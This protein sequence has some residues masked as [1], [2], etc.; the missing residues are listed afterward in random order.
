EIDNNADPSVTADG[1]HFIAGLTDEG[2]EVALG[3][4][5]TAGARRLLT[6]LD[7]AALGDI[8]WNTSQV[9]ASGGQ[10]AASH[11]YTSTGV[12]NVMVRV[13]DSNGNVAEETF[14]VTVGAPQ[15]GVGDPELLVVT[16]LDDTVALDGFVSLRE[17]ILAINSNTTVGDAVAGPSTNTIQFAVGLFDSPG[18][19]ELTGGEL[20][21]TDEVSILGPG[22]SLLTIDAGFD[23]R[24]FRVKDFTDSVIDVS[25]SGLTLANGRQ[26]DAG[27]AIFNTENLT[28]DDVRLLDSDHGSLPGVTRG[29][30]IYTVGDLAI[31]NSTIAGNSAMF[32]GGIFVD[33]GAVVTIVNSTISGNEATRDGG[34]IYVRNGSV[35]L[36]NSTISGNTAALAGGGIYQTSVNMV[37]T[38]VTVAFNEANQGGGIYS[39]FGTVTALNTIISNNAAA[40]SPDAMSTIN[41]DHN[42]LQNA[43]GATLTGDNNQTGVDPLLAPLGDFGGPTQTHYLLGGSPAIDA[44]TDVGAPLIDQRGEARPQEGD[45][46]GLVAHDIGAVEVSTFA[47]ADAYQMVQ[48]ETLTIDALQGVLANDVLPQGDAVVIDEPAFGDLTLNADGSFTYTPLADFSGVVSFTYRF[49]DADVTSNAATVTITIAESQPPQIVLG[50]SSGEELESD[51]QSFTWSITDPDNALFDATIVV[52]QD[53]AI[54]HENDAFDGS[55]EFDH[56]GIGEFT[57]E[58]EARDVSNRSATATRTVTV[59]A[60]P[61][62]ELLAVE[63]NDPQPAEL[64][65]D[66]EESA[67]HESEEQLEETEPVAEQPI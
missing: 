21:I 22:R 54:V 3:P 1:N 47:A 63:F 44:G 8:G 49:G 35:S 57:I 17:A 24:V 9:S 11:I 34:G 2:R 41:G 29:G 40:S 25:I 27:G 33:S 13:T 66:D 64:V 52:R 51:P 32:G 5:L 45:G 55:F 20:R 15:P 46:V 19:I 59:V 58:V 50:G 31:S 16:T 38:N 14:A 42:I 26:P 6:N 39:D 18:V 60:D 48:G 10:I 53:G 56:L 43:S 30:A 36:T 7:V 62:V 4:T 12:F 61:V 23:S 28:L 67:I 37:L 65:D